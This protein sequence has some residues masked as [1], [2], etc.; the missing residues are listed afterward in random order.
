MPSE[1]WKCGSLIV[2]AVLLCH[3]ARQADGTGGMQH[4]ISMGADGWK[5]ILGSNRPSSNQYQ[6]EIKYYQNP[7]LRET[8]KAEPLPTTTPGTTQNNATRLDQKAMKTIS[9]NVVHPGYPKGKLPPHSKNAPQYYVLPNHGSHGPHIPL[10][11][12]VYRNQNQQGLHKKLPLKHH[13]HNTGKRVKKPGFGQLVTA[14]STRNEVYVP[15]P[16]PGSYSFFSQGKNVKTRES[17]GL[18]NEGQKVYTVKHPHMEF[19]SH[20]P[21]NSLYQQANQPLQ[22]IIFQKQHV[23]EVIPPYQVDSYQ[24]LSPPP[25]FKNYADASQGQ[26]QGINPEIRKPDDKVIFG[27]NPLGPN[28]LILQLP[29]YEANLFGFGQQTQNGP[30][31][32]ITREKIQQYQKYPSQNFIQVEGEFGQINHGARRPV[33]EYPKKPTYEVTEGKWEEHTSSSD[34]VQSNVELDVPPF[35]PTPYRPDKA[36]PTSPTQNEVS[37]IFGQLSNVVK[38]HPESYTRNSLFFDVKEVSTHYPILGKPGYIPTT[39]PVEESTGKS[40]SRPYIEEPEKTTEWEQQTTEQPVKI[41]TNHRRRRP[42]LPRTT[43]P[44]VELPTD[45]ITESL[46]T[47]THPEV[48]DVET[49][50]PYRPRRPVRP[51]P[52]SEEVHHSNRHRDRHRKRPHH[53]NRNGPYR[54][55]VRPNR[56]ESEERTTN[57]PTEESREE[58]TEVLPIIQYFTTQRYKGHEDDQKESLY[59]PETQTEEAQTERIKTRRRP[60]HREQPYRINEEQG[61]EENVHQE[62]VTES[63]Q[64]GYMASYESASQEDDVTLQNHE[65]SKILDQEQPGNEVEKNS[66]TT[67][68]TEVPTSPTTINIPENEVEYTTLRNLEEVVIEEISKVTTTPE[69]LTTTTTTT[70]TKSNRRRPIKYN[71]SSRP[72]F[73]VK[74]YRQRLNQYSSTSTTSTEFPKPVSDNNL[75]LRF[76]TRLRRPISSTSTTTQVYEETTRS[77]FIPKEP[78]YTATHST[79]EVITEKNVKAVNTRLRPFGRTKPTTEFPTTTMKISIK[80]NLFSNRRR[81]QIHSLKTRIQNSNRTNEPENRT[82]IPNETEEHHEIITTTDNAEIHRE[83]TTEKIQTEREEEVEATTLHPAMDILKNDAFEYSQRVSDLTSSMKDE[84]ETFKAIPS[85]S[86]RVPNHYTI[87]TEDP[88]LP[89]EAFFSNINDKG[90]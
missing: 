51:R 42:T 27:H 38:K 10:N 46:E 49:E 15:A 73:S 57:K 67:T 8:V 24:N 26:Q 31:V 12:V 48:M 81:P 41:Q 83:Q 82:D 70:P 71:A 6:D 75:R 39:E 87:S 9:I 60:Y 14:H 43:T 45:P 68:T 58:A 76:P 44:P 37:T 35:L 84:Y 33:T 52:S 53:E 17:S 65:S 66:Y 64:S 89:L 25:I 36:V 21:P 90:K 20:F 50:R 29:S 56:Y 28:D 62:E 54:K 19:S 34:Q 69:P 59:S 7:I 61:G 4:P 13:G 18:S 74:D 79:N 2:T 22:H 32:Q 23:N 11:A 3:L 47:T 55:R 80:P 72:R 1:R 85:N 5:P 16:S 86:R 78:R 88:I 63:A 40:T 77:R 30:S